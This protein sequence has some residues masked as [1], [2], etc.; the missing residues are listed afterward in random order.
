MKAKDP[1]ARVAAAMRGAPVAEPSTRDRI[2]GAALSIIE[3]EGAGKATV[4]A[5]A[6]EAGVN[7][8]AINY[9]YRTKEELMDAAI[10]SSWKHASEDLRKFLEVDAEAI[11]SGIEALLLYLL[12]GG[13]TFPNVT[14]AY[15]L[16][17]GSSGPSPLILES[18][19]AFVEEF[20]GIIAK[21]LGIPRDDA[22]VARTG[23]LYFFCLYTALVPGSLPGAL[24]RDDFALAARVLSEDYLRD[25]VR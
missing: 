25:I 4:R 2:L 1:A 16:G 21:A 17:A 22:L 19:K 24:T 7:I 23:A 5:I 15:L 6:A 11:G 3:K 18:Q 13:K 14:S 9:H 8:A 20:A 10:S 12:R